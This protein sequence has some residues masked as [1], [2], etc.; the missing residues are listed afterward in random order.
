MATTGCG[1]SRKVTKHTD[2]CS[3]NKMMKPQIPFQ[4]IVKITVGKKL[5]HILQ[6]IFK[7]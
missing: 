4:N 3:N 1:T 5:L 7:H 6:A 2:Q